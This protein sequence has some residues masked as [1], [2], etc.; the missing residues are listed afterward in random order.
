[1][2]NLYHYTSVDGFE[3]IVKNNSIRMTKSE[4]LN[5]PYDCHLFVKLVEKYLDANESEINKV[6]GQL[7]TN[8]V[9]VT[10]LYKEKDCNLIKYIEYIQKNIGLYVM[11]L[12]QK[13]DE[14]NMWNYYGHGGMELKF[15]I[16]ELVDSLRGT[17]ISEKEYLT[18][19]NVIYANPELDIEKISVPDFSKFIL[20]SK[21]SQ[22]IFMEHRKFIKDNS[23]YHAYQLYSISN[24]GNFIYIYVKGYI[25]TLEYLIKQNQ[26]NIN[27]E[28]DVVF[29]RVFDNI[30]KLNNFFYW[31]HDLSLYML[32]LSALIKSDTY[33]Y[34]DEH[35]IVYFEYNIDGN[36]RKSEEYGVKSIDNNR[37]LYPYIVFEKDCMLKESLKSVIVSPITRNL[38]I[39][40]NS[41]CETLKKFLLGNGFDKSVDIKYSKHMIRW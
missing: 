33:Q 16:G 24:L 12:T 5:D 36:K 2:I 27:T 10:E 29:E 28:P 31:K 39:D 18:N 3:G 17:F 4:F 21:D 9:E 20:M 25:T 34:E 38:P 7:S 11:S 15:S 26:I 41:Y 19:A 14:M 8:K 37:F 23:F 1:M 13:E 35:R 22:N 6:I 32:V 30:S 40:K